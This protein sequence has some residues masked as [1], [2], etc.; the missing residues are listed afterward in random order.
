MSDYNLYAAG[1]VALDYMLASGKA[2]VSHAVVEFEDL[3]DYSSNEV[4]NLI[5]Y[6]GEWTQMSVVMSLRVLSHHG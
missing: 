5:L 6:H 2:A 1:A 3:G 4:S